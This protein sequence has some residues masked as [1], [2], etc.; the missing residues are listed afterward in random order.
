MWI[1]FFSLK[2]IEEN[3]YVYLLRIRKCSVR[4]CSNSARKFLEGTGGGTDKGTTR[5]D[6]P[7]KHELQEKMRH[8][9]L[10]FDHNL[11]VLQMNQNKEKRTILYTFMRFSLEDKKFI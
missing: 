4:F 1:T 2:L 11:Y 3:C 7:L 8:R 5:N 6:D 9:F 10:F